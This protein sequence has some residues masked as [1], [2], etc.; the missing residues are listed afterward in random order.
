MQAIDI[1]D[2][3]YNINCLDEKC[4]IFILKKNNNKI[5][6]LPMNI[7]KIFISEKINVNDIKIPFGCDVVIYDTYG[8]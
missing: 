6:N 4:E 7:K 5:T 3:S 1:N 8:M 2:T